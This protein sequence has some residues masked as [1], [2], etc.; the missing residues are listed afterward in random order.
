MYDDEGTGD[1]IYLNIWA[2]I[3]IGLDILTRNNYE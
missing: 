1:F 2:S 3:D